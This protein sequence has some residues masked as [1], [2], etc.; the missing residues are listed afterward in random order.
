MI[1]LYTDPRCLDHAA[2]PG[3][4]EVPRRLRSILETLDAWGQAP[5]AV[6]AAGHPHAAAAVAALHSAEYIQRFQRAV[7]RGD[8][9][10]DSADNPI[11][12][13]TWDAA[14]GAI[15]TVLAAADAVAT[16]ERVFAA[17]RPPGH[18]A[19]ADRAMGFCFFNNVA[20]AAEYLVRHHGL[21]RVAI[22]DFDVHHGNGTQHLFETRGDV[23]FASS[24]Q[25]PFYP[26]TG[27]AEERG[28]GDGRGATLNVPLAA[29]TGDAAL[30]TALDEEIL[31]ALQGFAPQALLI[32][33]GFD[34]W[35][36]D[37]LGGLQWSEETF[38]YL[39][40]RLASLAEEVC[41]GRL[42][43]VL[44]GGYDLAHLPRLVQSYL[45]GIIDFRA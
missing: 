38:H 29:G 35:R 2:P 41:A 8:G 3:Y 21:E 36:E 42:F 23:F 24:H 13:K 7:E 34:A 16:G 44:E 25:F 18:H 9:I 20:V 4:P 12:S 40:Q 10:L 26:G 1:A 39:G 22:Y 11:S 6:V 37:P 17:V 14:W 32:S 27:A 15:D 30:R 45:E 19:E 33:A 28:L 5:R 43:S 31:P